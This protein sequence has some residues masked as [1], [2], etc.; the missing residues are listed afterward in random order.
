VTASASVEPLRS[1][2]PLLT[3]T[4]AAAQQTAFDAALATLARTGGPTS[5][6]LVIVDRPAPGM[7]LQS[8]GTESSTS[9]T[10]IPR[11]QGRVSRN[12]R[13]RQRRALKYTLEA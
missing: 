12:L 9:A 6:R 10:G 1:A 3:T 5:Q 2:S 8:R 4:A 11:P 13:H 7:E